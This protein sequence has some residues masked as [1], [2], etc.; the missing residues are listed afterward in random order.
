MIINIAFA[1][2]PMRWLVV[3]VLLLAFASLGRASEPPVRVM[4]PPVRIVT[5]FSTLHDASQHPPAHL[6][7]QHDSYARSETMNQ[8][9]VTILTGFL[10]SGKTTFRKTS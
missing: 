3:T 9:P 5:T 6:G 8:I 4:E 2:Q 1:T 10:G 7:N